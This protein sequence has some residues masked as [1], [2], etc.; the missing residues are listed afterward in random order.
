MKILL[1]TKHDLIG[2]MMLNVLLPELVARHD[3][4]VLLA[5]RRR[6]ELEAIPELAW[7]KCFEQ[8]LTAKVLFPLLDKKRGHRGS[9]MVSNAPDRLSFEGLAQAYGVSF[10]N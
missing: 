2:S 9:E 7:M 3:V 6:P 1:C 8:D 5:N 4:S 10:T